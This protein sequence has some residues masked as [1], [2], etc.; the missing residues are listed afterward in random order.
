MSEMRRKNIFL[1]TL[2]SVFLT[3][4]FFYISSDGIGA[5]KELTLG[6]HKILIR[7]V[8]SD[9]DKAKGLSGVPNIKSNEGMLFVFDEPD[10]HSFWMKDMLFPIDIIWFD[11]NKKV[12]H[13]EKNVSPDTYPRGFTP[14][15]PA[16][17]VLET[18]AGI[19]EEYNVNLGDRA[20]W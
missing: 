16:Q 3:S 18:N 15:F 8:F 5:A 20:E 7:E 10:Y 6:E 1:A 14:G 13:I 9:E 19:S 2:F 12:V 11:E 17:Y 4:Y